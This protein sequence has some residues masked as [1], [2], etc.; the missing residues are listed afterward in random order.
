MRTTCQ[1]SWHQEQHRQRPIGLRIATGTS[2]KWRLQTLQS[3]QFC[4]YMPCC[5][6]GS[7]IIGDSTLEIQILELS[8][9]LAR[10]PGPGLRRKCGPGPWAWARDRAR[11]GPMHFLLNIGPGGRA[12]GRLS[13]KTAKSQTCFISN[14]LYRLVNWLPNV[15]NSF[16]PP[17]PGRLCDRQMRCWQ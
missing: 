17:S 4:L 7:L 15:F 9:P 13:S 2:L 14:M 8:R 5:L 10:P 3:S 6:F 12:S 11:A 1:V 16:Q